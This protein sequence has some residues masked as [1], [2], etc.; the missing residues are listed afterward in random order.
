MFVLKFSDDCNR[1]PKVISSFSYAQH[2]QFVVLY[3]VE[4]L[5]ALSVGSW[6]YAKN[7]ALLESF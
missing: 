6:Q 2:K 4:M 3:S 5:M 7:N 1:N